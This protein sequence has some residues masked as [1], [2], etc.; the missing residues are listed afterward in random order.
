MMCPRTKTDHK[1]GCNSQNEREI[2]SLICESIG[3]KSFHDFSQLTG[4]LL[5]LKITKMNTKTENP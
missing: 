5:L 1:P 4:Y 3:Q 2:Q